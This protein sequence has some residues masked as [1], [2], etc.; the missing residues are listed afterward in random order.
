[1]TFCIAGDCDFFPPIN[2]CFRGGNGIYIDGT[3]S[4]GKTESCKT[5]GNSPLCK[6]SDFEISAIEVF[7]LGLAD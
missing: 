2:H 1:M 7:G 6:S 4:R 3:L 5:F